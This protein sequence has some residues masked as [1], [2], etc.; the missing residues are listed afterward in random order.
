MIVVA[1]IQLQR[2]ASVSNDVIDSLSIVR[3]KF[4][5]QSENRFGVHRTTK[6][7]KR[8]I[9]IVYRRLLLLTL[10]ILYTRAP[11]KFKTQTWNTNVNWKREQK[12]KNTNNIFIHSLLWLSHVAAAA[13]F[14]SFAFVMVWF[15]FSLSLLSFCVRAEIAFVFFSKL[16]F[17]ANKQQKH[18]HWQQ[19]KNDSKNRTRSRHPAS[20]KNTNWLL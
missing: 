2:P 18:I 11:I 8:F 19:N 20:I 6:T 17:T 14:L 7:W 16:H 4:P 5:S 3:S 15:C 13:A 9:F 10:S 12:K 1:P